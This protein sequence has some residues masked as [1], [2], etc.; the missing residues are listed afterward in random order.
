LRI[1]SYYRSRVGFVEVAT[2]EYDLGNILGDSFGF[3]IK[4]Y[5][6]IP[7]GYERVKKGNCQLGDL[8][9]YGDGLIEDVDGLNGYPIESL[10][11][12]CYR[13]ILKSETL[14]DR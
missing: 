3:M 1:Y 7:D 11:A 5:A 12:K 10:S 14:N 9:Q 2:G 13:K 8:I 6:S 4:K